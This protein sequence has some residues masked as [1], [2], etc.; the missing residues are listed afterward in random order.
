MIG[1][2]II[3]SILFMVFGDYVKDNYDM[4]NR[5]YNLISTIQSIALISFIQS[6]IG[7]IV[8]GMINYV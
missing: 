1:Q 8:K 4:A 5:L 7:L 6:I 3:I 2:V